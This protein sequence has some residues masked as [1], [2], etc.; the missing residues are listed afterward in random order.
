MFDLITHRRT[1]DILNDGKYKENYLK[2]SSSNL[3]PL[4]TISN[5][6][7]NK[8]DKCKLIKN[9]YKVDV[10]DETTIQSIIRLRCHN[11]SSVI[12][13]VNFANENH[14]GGYPGMDWNNDIRKVTF[15]G[16]RANAQ[17]E[18]IIEKSTAF[19]S[20]VKIKYPFNSEK[21]CFLGPVQIFA[22]DHTSKSSKLIS[23]PI[24]AFMITS[25]SI[26][27]RKHTQW[28]RVKRELILDR[29]RKR[30]RCQLLAGQKLREKYSK[31]KKNII[32][33]GAYGCGAFSPNNW[34]GNNSHSK[35]VRAIANIYKSELED[36]FCDI[37]D[38]IVFAVPTF[39]S[40]NENERN[41]INYKAFFSV[42]K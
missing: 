3:P 10:V 31:K 11:P 32:V 8:T 17:E 2:Y 12:S 34:N 40:T 5:K 42:F 38:H 18:N 37:F 1:V 6:S 14:I 9:K 20:L 27:L 25:A 41:Y 24:N 4:I 39:K 7:I 23:D 13:F 33:L 22:T 19:L 29:I 16:E 28:N 35:Y 30:I 26:C 15:I 36:N 21:K